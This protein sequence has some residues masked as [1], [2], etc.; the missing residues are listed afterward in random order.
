MPASP[1]SSGPCKCDKLFSSKLYT[2]RQR[3]SHTW[4]QIDLHIC[5]QSR[6]EISGWCVVSGVPTPLASL[7]DWL[8]RPES[9]GA[10]TKFRAIISSSHTHIE[11]VFNTTPSIILY[12]MA[13][14]HKEPNRGYWGIYFT[15]AIVQGMSCVAG[16]CSLGR[17]DKYSVRHCIGTVDGG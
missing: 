4:S 8:R 17:F 1:A 7:I 16:C 3:D 2:E 5:L 13:L 6:E 11:R 12:T 9:N 10:K 15:C 14:P